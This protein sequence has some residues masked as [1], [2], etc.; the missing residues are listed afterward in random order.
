MQSLIY[1]FRELTNS[2]KTIPVVD[3]PP[4]EKVDRISVLATRLDHRPAVVVAQG[5]RRA[6][7]VG[8]GFEFL[9]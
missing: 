1:M 2:P 4:A 5:G 9:F 7:V 3:P 6:D 8:A